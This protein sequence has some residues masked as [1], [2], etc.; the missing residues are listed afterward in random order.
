MRQEC[1]RSSLLSHRR[2][3]ECVGTY[4]ISNKDSNSCLT[5]TP[6]PH[7]YLFFYIFFNVPQIS[8]PAAPEG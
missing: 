7:F 3:L 6:P 8:P 1:V 4:K 2:A 5:S